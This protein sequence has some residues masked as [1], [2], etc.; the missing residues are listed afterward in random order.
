MGKVNQDLQDFP[1]DKG[2]SDRPTYKAG[3][4]G[5]LACLLFPGLRHLWTG[6][7]DA[8]ACPGVGLDAFRMD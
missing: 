8:V 4:P 6:L 5:D 1:G 7:Y 3:S 2:V